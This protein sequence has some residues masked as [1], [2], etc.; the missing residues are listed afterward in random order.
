VAGLA[1]GVGLCGARGE[2]ACER[3]WEEEV[4][5]DEFADD[6]GVDGCGGVVAGGGW[7][8]TDLVAPAALL[9]SGGGKGVGV[10]VPD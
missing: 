9:V 2:S 6:G 3:F 1:E 4:A 8:G 10:S 5:P 7:D